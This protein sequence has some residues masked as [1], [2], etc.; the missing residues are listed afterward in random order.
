MSVALDESAL[1][2]AVRRIVERF[3]PDEVILFGSRARGDAREDSDYDLLIIGP[4]DEP[5]GKRTARVSGALSDI[6]LREDIHW[7]TR[8]EIDEWQLVRSHFI[9]RI[10]RDGKALYV[11]GS[12]RGE[13]GAPDRDPG[14]STKGHLKMPV[15]H[16]RIL[17]EKAANDLGAARVTLAAGIAYDTVCFHAQQA[18]EKSLKALLAASDVVPP[19]THELEDLIAL[20]KKSVAEWPFDDAR[21]KVLTRYAVDI[22]YAAT[23]IPPRKEAAAAL[24]TAEEVHRLTARLIGLASSD[25]DSKD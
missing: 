12:P 11:R 6:D 17:W 24:E 3:D 16:A 20:A 21:I 13:P 15:D 1:G 18:A 19:R 22:R 14:T 8:D 7:W 2:I 4:S 5:R 10:L 23:P 25:P 9:N